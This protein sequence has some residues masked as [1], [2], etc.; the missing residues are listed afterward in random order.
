M[1]TSH[2]FIKAKLKSNDGLKVHREYMTSLHKQ[3]SFGQSILLFSVVFASLTLACIWAC[4]EDGEFTARSSCSSAHTDTALF[5]F[6]SFRQPHTFKQGH[7]LWHIQL[8]AQ[9]HKQIKPPSVSNTHKEPTLYSNADRNLLQHPPLL[10]SSKFTGLINWFYIVNMADCLVHGVLYSQ[11]QL[12]NMTVKI[13]VNNLSSYHSESSLTALYT[14][15][16][17]VQGAS[18]QYLQW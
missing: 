8:T 4:C 15:A 11:L 3:F 13:S 2:Y 1:P 14:L 9:M 6:Y 17:S 12:V 7:H 18:Y 10:F 5:S 16:V